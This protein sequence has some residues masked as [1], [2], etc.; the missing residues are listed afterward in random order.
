MGRRVVYENS[1]NVSE[2]PAACSL[3]VDPFVLKMEVTD[4]FRYW[5]S[6][7]R[8]TWRQASEGCS[9]KTDCHENIMCRR[10]FMLLDDAASIAEVKKIV[11]CAEL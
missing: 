11:A 2:T 4:S 5:V 7:H 9:M 3:H 10:F 6:V 8:I 1:T